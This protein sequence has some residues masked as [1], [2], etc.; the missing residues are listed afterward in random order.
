MPQLS[1]WTVFFSFQEHRAS[2]TKV[3][4]QLNI[5]KF[6]IFSAASAADQKTRPKKKILFSIEGR[7]VSFK[8]H[9]RNEK[10]FGNSRGFLIYSATF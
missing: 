10:L 7:Y 9:W 3:H 6:F 1:N 5:I 8:I 4:P 2:T